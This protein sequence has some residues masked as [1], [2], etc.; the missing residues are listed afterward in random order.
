MF[1]S[2]SALT[3]GFPVQCLLC[4]SVYDQAV[5]AQEL[6]NSWARFV[7]SMSVKHRHDLTL[8]LEKGRALTDMVAGKSDGLLVASCKAAGT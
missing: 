2:D 3:C 4:S 6:V 7:K 1:S 8:G 5:K